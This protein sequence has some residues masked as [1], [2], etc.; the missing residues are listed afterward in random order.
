MR[1]AVGIPVL[2]AQAVAKA[3]GGVDVNPSTPHDRFDQPA[4][5]AVAADQ[6]RRLLTAAP[7]SALTNLATGAIVIWVLRESVSLNRLWAWGLVLA[8]VHG[9]HLGLWM[10]KR[11]RP[12][13]PR[14]LVRLH[15]VLRAGAW[16]SG[17][18]WGAVPLVLFPPGAMQQAFIVFFTAGVSGAA[19]TALAFDGWAAFLFVVSALVPLMARLF[20]LHGSMAHAASL[21]VA[22]Y[23]AY[24]SAAIHHG[25]RQFV[26]S[27]SWRNQAFENAAQREQQ[28][29]RL[30]RLAQFNALLAQANQL[31]STADDAGALYAAIC[32]A[33]VEHAALKSVWIGRLDTATQD[34]DV[35]AAATSGGES[36][37]A[38]I[39]AELDGP[40]APGLARAAWRED[41]PVF[42]PRSPSGTPATG[43]NAA[44]P[45]HEHG[46]IASVL[47][48][49]VE[50]EEVFDE[51]TRDLLLNLVA[52]IERGLQVVW[53]RNRI[54]NLQKLHHALMSEG[55]VVLQARSVPEMLVRSCQKL[56]Q[57][58]QFHAAWVARPDER[59]HIDVIARAGTG[60][61]QLDA[62]D[63]NINDDN[64]SPLAIRVWISHGVALSDDLLEDS[65][66]APWHASLA[67]HGWRA[68]LA[69]PVFRGGEIWAVL[70]FV[71]PHA[72]VFDTQTIELCE[73]VAELLGH[74]L[75]ELDLKQRLGDLQ[76]Q[77]AHR[78]RHDPLTGLA[79]R[80]ALEQHLPRAIAR[81]HA[82][83]RALALGMI[84][85]DNFKPVN[86]TWGHEAGDQL[87]RE[88]G[89]RLQSRIRES[90]FL[91]RLGGD[92]FVVVIEGID[93]KRVIETLEQAFARLHQAVETPFALGTGALIPIDMTMGI[94]LYPFDAGDAD[95][96]MRQADGAMYQAKLHKGDR[97]RWWQLGAASA[98]L[99]RHAKA[100]DAR[101]EAST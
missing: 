24:L 56:T 76:R 86:D 63:I 100:L 13:A 78:A 96:L 10:R 93:K 52:S 6:Y 18:A 82:H 72:H 8:L 101:A 40:A 61:S 92:E 15:R 21:M 3:K 19:M 75:D 68:A 2:P 80:F 12:A 45:V 73:R 4:Q 54:A 11:K 36:N 37:D 43:A 57:G 33:A 90:D 65:T 42:E 38:W 44:L 9:A 28:A 22:I 17:L 30:R 51:A 62:L 49:H 25:H 50:Q 5:A 79:N 74:G 58:T 70:V 84:D 47:S 14:A 83:G 60:A 48:V 46:R 69:A 64:K 77:E 81:A 26:Q 41:R 91:V 7:Y 31:G 95:S 16:L 53:Q 87:L 71:S 34:F 23:L 27:L 39:G 85:L 59:G 89:M 35:L 94:A 66:M 1:S 29:Q 32:E 67:A 99:F 55:D 98:E 97:Q 20:L 88:L